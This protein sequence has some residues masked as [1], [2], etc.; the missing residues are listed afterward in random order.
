MHVFEAVSTN[1]A[2]REFQD[3][4]LNEEHLRQIL[5]AGRLCQSGKNLQPWHFIVVRDKQLL[6]D[7][8]D[9]MR[10]DLDEPIVRKA[11]LAIAI[12]SDPNSEFNVLDAGRTAQ[13]M[14]LTAW[15]LG[16]GSCF[17]SGPE[18]P[19]R[20]PYREKAHDLLGIPDRLNL[21]DLVVF[22]YPKRRTVVRRKKRKELQEIASEKKYGNPLVLGES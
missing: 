20:E 4:P 17:M 11:P 22:G 21:V 15:E 1:I 6:N 19:D 7:L 9:L 14:T 8:A 10:G 16:I 2:V 13:N 18:Q 12:V 5:E 3:R